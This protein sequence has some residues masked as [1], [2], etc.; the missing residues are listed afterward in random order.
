MS[1]RSE[2]IGAKPKK[3]PLGSGERFR[4]LEGSLSRKGVRDP[5]ALAAWIGRRK[6]GAKRFNA[7]SRGGR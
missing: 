7:L 3:P 5:G 4:Q 1:R 6:F 2:I